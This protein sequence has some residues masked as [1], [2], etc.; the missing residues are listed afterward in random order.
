MKDCTRRRSGPKSQA[1]IRVEATTASWD[2]S[3]VRLRKGVLQGDYAAEVH[4]SQSRAQGTVNQGVVDDN[5]Y[6]VEPVPE[7]SDTGGDGDRGNEKQTRHASDR[8]EQPSL[9][10]EQ[11]LE[12]QYPGEREGGGEGEPLDLLALHTL[13]RR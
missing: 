11:F 1:I 13:A 2:F 12:Y 10:V 8:F 5:V 4:E 9:G 3:P 7:H 6:V